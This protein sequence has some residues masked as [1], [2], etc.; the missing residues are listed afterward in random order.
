MKYIYKCIKTSMKNVLLNLYFPIDLI[1]IIEGFYS[2]LNIICHCMHYFSVLGNFLKYVHVFK[3]CLGILL[4]NIKA[5]GNR[6]SLDFLFVL[7]L[8]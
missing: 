5:K 2:L 6:I 3:T 7:Y 1:F 8:V 4:K